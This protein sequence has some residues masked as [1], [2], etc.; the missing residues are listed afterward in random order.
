MYYDDIEIPKSC[1]E[2]D[3]IDKVLNSL[4]LGMKIFWLTDDYVVKLVDDHLFSLF[5]KDS[6]TS[7]LVNYSERDNYQVAAEDLFFYIGIEAIDKITGSISFISLDMLV[8]H[9]YNHDSIIYNVDTWVDG[10]I[11]NEDKLPYKIDK[12]FLITDYFKYKDE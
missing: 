2:I 1:N 7:K 9:L 8:E 4:Q 10:Y 5:H 12:S 6:N 11:K 3:T